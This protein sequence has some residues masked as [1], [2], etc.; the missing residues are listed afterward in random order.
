[1]LRRG[2][3]SARVKPPLKPVPHVDQFRLDSK[4]QTDLVNEEIK[5]IA[6]VKFLPGKLEEW[7]RLTE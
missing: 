7:K 5:G 6:R 2:P 4:F 3:T 1:M